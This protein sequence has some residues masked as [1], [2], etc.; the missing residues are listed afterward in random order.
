MRPEAAPGTPAALASPADPAQPG[1]A[2]PPSEP[3]APIDETFAPETLETPTEQK[4]DPEPARDTARKWLAYILLILLCAIV[5]ASFATLWW[6]EAKF[7]DLKALLELI[8][9]PVIALVGSATGFYF[10][11]GGRSGKP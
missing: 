9:S 7:A 5:V 8:L 6:A 1:A 3:S 4:Y 2:P 10:G 11:G